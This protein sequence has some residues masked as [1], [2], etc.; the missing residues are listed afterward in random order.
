MSQPKGEL[1]I[2]TLAMPSS[3]NANGDIFG[4]WILSQMDLAAGILAKRSA[5]GR[6]VTVA[7]NGMSFIQAVHVGDLVTCYGHLVKIGR[8]SLTIDIEVWTEKFSN[9]EHAK[10]TEGT[11]TFVAVDEHGRPRVVSADDRNKIK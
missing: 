5:Y 8:T 1:V 11:F 2:Q 9:G 10:V 7:I 3:T 6:A 4:G